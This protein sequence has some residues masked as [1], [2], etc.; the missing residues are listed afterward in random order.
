MSGIAADDAK[1]DLVG[2]PLMTQSGS[3]EDPTAKRKA[4]DPTTLVYLCVCGQE[5]DLSNAGSSAAPLVCPRCG[6]VVPPSASHDPSLTVTLTIPPV[7]K[8][9]LVGETVDPGADTFPQPHD[10]D[11]LEQQL[12]QTIDETSYRESVREGTSGGATSDGSSLAAARVF[13]RGEASESMGRRLGHFVLQERLGAGGMGA[14]YRALDTS[15]E[16]YVAVKVLRESSGSSGST[17]D[18]RQVDRLRREAVSQARLNHPRVVTI[19]YVGRE[20]EEPF[21]AMEL[22][23]GP[24][25]QQRLLKGPLHYHEVIRF[26]LQ[27]ADALQAA[28][29]SGLVHGDIKPSNL[30][31]SGPGE[32]KLSDFGLARRS[33]S[34][35]RDGAVSGTPHYIAPELV[36]G[37][38]P[39]RRADMYA[40]GVTLFELAFGRRPFALQG[41]TLHERLRS[42]QTAPIEFPE[43]WPAE[44]PESFRELLS[45]L[46]AKNPADRYD[47]YDSLIADLRRVAPVGSTLA[48]RP[49]RAIAWFVDMACLMSLQVPL[50][51][52]NLILTVV[53]GDGADYWG[54]MGTGIPFAM[55][56]FFFAIL[57]L[58][59]WVAVPLLALWW[60]LRR[61]RTPGRYLMQLRVVDEH[62]L[63]PPRRAL[64]LRNVMRYM[65]LWVALAFSLPLVFV[66]PWAELIEKTLGRIWLLVD[67]GFM[68]GSTRRA[69]HDRICR[70]HVVIDQRNSRRFDLGQQA[71]VSTQDS[72]S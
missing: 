27:I 50:I 63:P 58:V 34:S 68:L 20:E 31:M 22:L 43:K 49:A 37:K 1:Q 66:L 30:L 3:N 61:W 26:A 15:L 51:L 16:R 45:R 29:A 57:A 7:G 11:P 24:S 19:Y 71:P 25:L 46:L 72:A 38:P 35:S 23:P 41:D 69:L 67:G 42:H 56:R 65:D 6:S 40:L 54:Q 8:A 70:T 5:I 4:S 48:G 14:V 13:S 52:P 44:I 18:H 53:G 64:V 21:L 36:D 10:A 59:G 62:G 60:D 47:S 2:F 28:D 32:I 17:A 9:A 12:D 33:G 39:D 55:V